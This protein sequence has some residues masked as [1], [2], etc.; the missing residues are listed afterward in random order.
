MSAPVLMVDDEPRVLDGLRRSLHGKVVIA[1]ASS[2]ADGLA[3]VDA[4][5]AEK[6]P[7]PVVVSDM[8]MPGMNGAE[9]LRQVAE[10]S[11]DS[12]LMLL[13]GQADL[14]ST[15]SA[16]NSGHLFRFLTKPCSPEDLQRAVAAAQRQHELVHAEK[17][18]IEKTLNGAVEVLTQV[19]ALTN[20]EALGRTK[21]VRTLVEGVMRL[22]P[23][24]DI[25]ELRLAAM[26]GQIGCVAVPDELM[27]RK[28]GG[29]RLTAQE[30][31]IYCRHATLARDL[32]AR[33]PRLERVAEWVGVQEERTVF[34]YESGPLPA[35]LV[36]AAVMAFIAESE[37]G[38]EPWA[39]ASRLAS[40]RRFPARLTDVLVEASAS[41]GGGIPHPVSAADMKVGMELCQDVYTKTGM[42][43]VKKGEVLSEMLAA[44]LENFAE[45]VGVEEPITVI[46]PV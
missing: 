24:S 28:T 6:R 27:H 33:I 19:L 9:F 11:P 29:E 18:L 23:V 1:T 20:P 5:L 36:F 17:E 31:D 41:T 21:R 30:E 46:D 38:G 35:G 2:G 7:F 39:A 14:E 16:V 13:S 37:R 8:M 44:R 43:L 22:L 42:R 25:W 45:S 12:I 3:K 34:T 40:S 32:L 26:L 15:I 10:R 4:A